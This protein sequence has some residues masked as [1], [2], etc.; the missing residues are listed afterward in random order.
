[1]VYKWEWNS[2]L[3]SDTSLFVS[4]GAL[5]FSLWGGWHFSEE[6]SVYCKL[7]FTLFPLL[8]VSS[9]FVSP[10]L[11]SSN[12]PVT[13]TKQILFLSLCVFPSPE[14]A[15]GQQGG[16]GNSQHAGEKH[17]TV[18]V[19]L[20]FH[21]AGPTPP[22]LQRHDEQQRPWWAIDTH[23]YPHAFDSKDAALSLGYR[24]THRHVFLY[25]LWETELGTWQRFTITFHVHA[26]LDD[27]H[28]ASVGYVTRTQ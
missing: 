21:P 25:L 28:N 3:I 6:N 15:V 16:D 17:H 10:S 2:I 22:R 19:W 27:G 26:V 11:L 7:F 14:P 24:Q 20:P 1:M 5:L 13:F 12:T 4:A 8:L 23:T 18:E 9:V